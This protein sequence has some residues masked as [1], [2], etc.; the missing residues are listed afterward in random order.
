[1]GTL[2][3][4]LM[5]TYGGR[6]GGKTE[7]KRILS[8]QSFPSHW[9]E[10]C[11]CWSKVLSAMWM[12]PWGV[13]VI[14]RWWNV[15]LCNI[16]EDLLSWCQIRLHIRLSRDLHLSDSSNWLLGPVHYSV[17]FCLSLSHSVLTAP[18]WGMSY[19]YCFLLSRTWKLR[20]AQGQPDGQR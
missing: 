15:T 7:G 1:M 17:S 5:C 8:S 11:I 18:Q 10:Y 2:R 9:L 16:K 13:D 12:R 6:W 3:R 19:V 20:S 4:S 14:W